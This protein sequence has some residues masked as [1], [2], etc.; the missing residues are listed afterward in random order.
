MLYYSHQ[1]REKYQEACHGKNLNVINGVL[2]EIYVVIQYFNESV[3][4][5]ICLLFYSKCENKVTSCTIQN[6]SNIV[7]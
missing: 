4:K 1:A 5:A 7:G 6:D 3:N 2:T